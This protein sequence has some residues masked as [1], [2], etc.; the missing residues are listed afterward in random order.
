MST[1]RFATSTFTNPAH[2]PPST[3][4]HCSS[5]TAARPR[6]RRY[7]SGFVATSPSSQTVIVQ[8]TVVTGASSAK[9]H[10]WL[11]SSTT[12]YHIPSRLPPALGVAGICCRRR[13]QSYSHILRPFSVCQASGLHILF[14]ATIGI[15]L[16]NT[17]SPPVSL[18][19]GGRLFVK[20]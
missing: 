9:L 4:S 19:R 1:E 11:H 15:G 12:D 16:W 3:L 14:T 2:L 20:I 7:T 13:Q 5:P 17:P 10:R 8:V 6:Y 18:L